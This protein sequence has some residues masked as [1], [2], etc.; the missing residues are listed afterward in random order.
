MMEQRKQQH[1]KG[2][3]GT[4][5][6]MT[7]VPTPATSTMTTTVAAAA[8]AATSTPMASYIHDNQSILPN[9][10]NHGTMINTPFQ[11]GLDK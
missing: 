8:T 3:F 4:S 11:I 10:I 7:S 5:L 9:I 1:R 6:T 2:L